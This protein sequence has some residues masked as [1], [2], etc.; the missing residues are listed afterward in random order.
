M[1]GRAIF[2]TVLAKG[3]TKLSGSANPVPAAKGEW[4]S[5]PSFLVTLVFAI[6]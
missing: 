5:E 4:L 1:V 2:T 6:G 3:G